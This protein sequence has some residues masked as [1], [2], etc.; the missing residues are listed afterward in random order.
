MTYLPYFLYWKR[1]TAPRLNVTSK[2]CPAPLFF[3]KGLNSMMKALLRPIMILL[4]LIPFI[5]GHYAQAKEIIFGTENHAPYNFIDPESN[6]IVGL[7]V[8]VVKA[9]LNAAHDT[10]SKI[11]IFPWARIYN[12]ALIQ[13]NVAIFSM[14]HTA[15]RE[16]LF[17]WVGEIHNSKNYLW[18][19]VSRSDIKITSRSDLFKYKIVVQRNGADHQTF[20]NIYGLDEKKNLH[21]VTDT[22]QRY[23]LIFN[24]HGDLFTEAPFTL[25]WNLESYKYDFINLEKVYFVP[26]LGSS[27]NLAFS[28]ETDDSVVNRYRHALKEIKANGEYQAII[29]KWTQ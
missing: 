7:G 22:K 15:A 25:K 10:D 26:E 14:T 16:P 9:M 23:K 6:E 3:G 24:Q 4:I 28:D 1:G 2:R 12:M 27:L 11:K 29:K 21:L 8:D 19:N 18:K 17:K 13:E 20:K 5:L